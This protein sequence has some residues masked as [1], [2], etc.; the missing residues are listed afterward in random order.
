MHS[1]V[2]KQPQLWLQVIEKPR[3]LGERTEKKEEKGGT[4]LQHIHIHILYFNLYPC[5]PAIWSTKLPVFRSSVWCGMPACTRLTM[6][7]LKSLL[8][9]WASNNKMASLALVWVRLRVLDTSR[10]AE[11]TRWCRNAWK[12][13]NS[14]RTGP[15]AGRGV[16]AHIYPPPHLSSCDGGCGVCVWVLHSPLVKYVLGMNKDKHL[17]LWLLH[18]LP[19]LS[20]I[21][22]LPFIFSFICSNVPQ[23]FCQSPGMSGKRHWTG[24]RSNGLQ[25]LL[26]VHSSRRRW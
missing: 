22:T 11:S 18:S 21:S 13:S 1:T 8:T 5:I 10:P 6:C 9:V 12:Q 3:N 20:F 16:V 23:L 19:L 15:S 7:S 4:Q 14:S 24:L 17:S 2:Q 26:K 25:S